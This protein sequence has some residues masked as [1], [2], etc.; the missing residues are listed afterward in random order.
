VRL[1]S[2]SGSD[3]VRVPFL[4]RDLIATLVVKP[5]ADL[6]SHLYTSR[7]YKGATFSADF[8]FQFRTD[9]GPSRAEQF[10]FTEARRST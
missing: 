3:R 2:L 9:G 1:A 5:A 7:I 4:K 8:S 10:N 6:Y